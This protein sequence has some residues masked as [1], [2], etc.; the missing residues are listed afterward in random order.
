VVAERGGFL[1]AGENRRALA[2]AIDRGRLLAAFEVP[3][4]AAA[5]TIVAPGTFDLQQPVQPGWS[6]LDVAARRQIAGDTVAIWKMANPDKPI[7]LRVALPD[8]PGSTLLFA[9]IRADWAAIGVDA[10]RVAPDATADL[11]L[12]DEVAPS[13][14]ASWYLRRFT[15]GNGPVCSEVA[16]KAVDDARDAVDPIER[17][18]R[19]ADADLRLAEIVPFIPIAQPLRWSLVAQRLAAFRTNNRGVHPL[20]HLR[21]E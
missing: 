14:S 16:D 6:G 10:V 15:C 3:D 2:M 20:N 5:V 17:A 8:G 19:I 11:R 7:R 1:S 9:A 13:Q 18:A 21:A 12:I 4:W